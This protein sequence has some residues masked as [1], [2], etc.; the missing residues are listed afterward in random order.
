MLCFS[1]TT[2]FEAVFVLILA[3]VLF[4]WLWSECEICV[5][6]TT[7]ANCLL[8]LEMSF[9]PP[10]VVTLL[11]SEVRPQEGSGVSPSL[12]DLRRDIFCLLFGLLSFCGVGNIPSLNTFSRLLLRD[13]FLSLHDGRAHPA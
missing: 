3:A 12:E 1:L 7:S 2:S 9:N 13:C 5:N 11:P 6:T 8:S 10:K 4:V